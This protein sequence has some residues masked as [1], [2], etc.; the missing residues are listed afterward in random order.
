MSRINTNVSSLFAQTTLSRTNDQLNTAMSRLSS[1]LRINSAADDPAGLIASEVLRSDMTAVSQAITNTDRADQLIQTADSALGQVSN[2]LNDIRGLV[3]EA[4]NDGALSAEQIAANQLQ[5][6]SSLEAIDR[7][8]RTTAFGGKKLLDG[9]LEVETNTTSSN[10]DN[11]DVQQVNLGSSGTSGTGAGTLFDSMQ[12]TVDNITVASQG[13]LTDGSRAINKNN[14]TNT[15]TIGTAATGGSTVQL[16]LANTTE[17]LA[18]DNLEVRFTRAAAADASFDTSTNTLTITLK[19]LDDGSVDGAHNGLTN[20]K[21][22]IEALA[23][24]SNATFSAGVDLSGNDVRALYL[25]GTQIS[26]NTARFAS[27]V[28]DTDTGTSNGLKLMNKVQDRVVQISGALGS[29]TFTFATG[30]TQAEMATAI[31]AM[32]DATGVSADATSGKLVLTSTEYGSDAFVD[33]EVISEGAGGTYASSGTGSVGRHTGSDISGTING[34]AASGKGNTLSINSGVLTAD[35]RMVA[36]ASAQSIFNISG[37]GANFQLGSDVITPQQA[38]VGIESV[39]TGSLGGESGTLYLLRTGQN[40][41]LATDSITAGKIVDEAILS[42]AN[43]RGRLGAFSATTLDSNKTALSDYLVNLTEA[44]S[45]LRDA[46]F[47][48]ESAALTRAQV[49]VQS[50]TSILA[51]ANQNPQN[52]L[53][54]IR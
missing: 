13:T 50:G 54:L 9:S 1:G 15:F 34:V 18:V 42:V 17:G 26:A 38:R 33:V 51:I 16:T 12:V 28:D 36:G 49:L 47:A 5:V 35:V 43:S 25:D 3:V 32:K 27:I 10:F 52:M 31:E 21:N 11:I 7:I 8:A 6:D 45:S 4:A 40:A 29:E 24:F 46:D 41:A 48:K 23:Q 30:A 53:A 14:A 39:S 2:L 19:S 20:L 22:E 44:E 37:G